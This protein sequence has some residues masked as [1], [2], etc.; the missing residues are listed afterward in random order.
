[1]PNFTIEQLPWQAGVIVIF[2]FILYRVARSIIA[3][4]TERMQF[5]ERQ[6]E[7]LTDNITLLTQETVKQNAMNVQIAGAVQ[8]NTAEIRAL[9]QKFDTLTRSVDEK[10]KT[11]EVS[12]E[13]LQRAVATLETLVNK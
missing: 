5:Q 6:Q 4:N 12:I 10:I 13:R 7:K 3:S 1:M 8:A 9:G 11:G 2:G